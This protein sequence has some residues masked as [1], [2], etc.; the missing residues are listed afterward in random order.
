[1]QVDAGRGLQAQPPQRIH[2]E[3]VCGEPG[4]HVCAATA[5]EPIALDAG[6]V[7][8]RLPERLWADGN[9]IDVTVQDQRTP[10]LLLGSMRADHVDCVVVAHVDWRET[11]VV[12]DLGHVDRPAVHLVAALPKCFVD[13]VLGGV[14][15]TA[16]RGV[17]N[18]ILG[19]ANLFLEAARDGIDDPSREIRVERRGL[20][21]RHRVLL[22]LSVAPT[23]PTDYR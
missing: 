16:L 14:L 3:D 23:P 17:A 4:L 15:V 10:L 19:E 2:G 5:V 6:L 18:Q 9:D 20:P 12:L 7:G 13:E 22:S 8:R 1:L 11:G 21:F